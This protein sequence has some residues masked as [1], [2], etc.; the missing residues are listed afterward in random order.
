MAWVPVAPHAEI[1]TA[2]LAIQV[3]VKA[4]EL[5]ILKSYS[6]QAGSAWYSR[7]HYFDYDADPPL[8]IVV[9]GDLISDAQEE[10]FSFA[11]CPEPFLSTITM[12]KD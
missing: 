8:L 5:T 10:P 7:R 4:A 12:F 2:G 6:G 3:V 1:V 11:Q 9:M